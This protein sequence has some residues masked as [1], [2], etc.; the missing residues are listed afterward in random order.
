MTVSKV[1]LQ[2]QLD[3]AVKLKEKNQSLQN[4][5]YYLQLGKVIAL[6]TVMSELTKV[7]VKGESKKI[8][9]EKTF[10]SIVKFYIDKKG[11]TKQQANAVAEKV[12]RDKLQTELSF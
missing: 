10:E 11:Y 3:E 4:S 6:R 9:V 5:E 7:P 1:W 12:V 2:E 8:D